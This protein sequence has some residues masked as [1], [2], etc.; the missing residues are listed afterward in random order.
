MVN[1]TLGKRPYPAF[2]SGQFFPPKPDN[3]AGDPVIPLF[4]QWFLLGT[5]HA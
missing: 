2:F 5:E 4:F 3:G 1:E